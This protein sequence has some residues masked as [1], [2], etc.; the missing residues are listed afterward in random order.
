MLLRES[1]GR[2]G[3]RGERGK[4]LEESSV[5]ESL[6]R[7]FAEKL[8]S[9]MKQKSKEAAKEREML[10]SFVSELSRRANQ[11]RFE[12]VTEKP[13]VSRGF[14]MKV[15]GEVF[16]AADGV[17]AVVGDVEIPNGAVVDRPLV[18]EGRIR[19]GANCQVLEKLKAL[20]GITIAEE[21]LVKA[22]LASGDVI[23]IGEN[24]VVEGDIHAESSII[25]HKGAKIN[26]E[27]ECESIVAY[28]EATD[29]I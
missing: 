5:I 20:H 22:D 19:I 17:T 29:S 13:K 21:C 7:L 11:R 14:C 23:E 24:T 15:F 12:P 18:V 3:I 27:I 6:E 8:R 4:G 1:R 26:G 25:L 2:F 28:E 9:V 16:H 10:T